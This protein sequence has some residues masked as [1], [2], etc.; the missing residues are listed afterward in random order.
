MIL[1]LKT[2]Q[3]DGF[4]RTFLSRQHAFSPLDGDRVSGNCWILFDFVCS[5]LLCCCSRTP[6]R[7]NL[8]D[9]LPRRIA[10]V[11]RFITTSEAIFSILIIFDRF[12]FLFNTVSCRLDANERQWDKFIKSLKITGINVQMFYVNTQSSRYFKSVR[13]IFERNDS[14][15]VLSRKYTIILLGPLLYIK[16][17]QA[18]SKQNKNMSSAFLNSASSPCVFTF[19][20][21][22]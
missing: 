1:I 14:V 17:Q 3:T 21:A 4:T 20:C 19:N 15:S 12:L 18:V 13:L 8:P 5:S 2:F 9:W 6:A 22:I 16:P 11:S 7:T 10:E